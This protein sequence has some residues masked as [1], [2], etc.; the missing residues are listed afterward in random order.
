MELTVDDNGLEIAKAIRDG[1][2]IAVSDGSFKDSHGTAAFILKGSLPVGRIVG[3]NVIPGAEES[4]TAYRS[5][6]GGVAGI[7]EALHCICRA[8]HITYG[9]VEVGLDGDQA[10]KEAFGIWPLD[11]S[12][13]DFDLLVHIRG[14]I[15]L[16]PLEL[17]SRWIESHQDNTR[18]LATLDRWG[19]LNVE[20]DGLTKSFGKLLVSQHPVRT[21]EMGT[22]DR[23]E[24][25]VESGQKK[26]L[27]F[28]L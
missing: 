21:R 8:N 20:C 10:R 2:A 6:L 1:T 7:L 27:C 11:P 23:Q 17:T 18:S 9:K 5:E 22:M 4:Q 15:R 25:A 24:E 16:S 14:M 12:R 3:V 26:D 28:C 13:P 19:K